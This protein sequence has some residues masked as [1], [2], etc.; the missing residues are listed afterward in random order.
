M[1]I[2]TQEKEF[3][4]DWEIKASLMLHM[5]I[6]ELGLAMFSFKEGE[7]RVSLVR[8]YSAKATTCR[9]LGTKYAAPR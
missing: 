7:N 1:V 6:V 8:I 5:V 4:S 9:Y 2:W 3:Y